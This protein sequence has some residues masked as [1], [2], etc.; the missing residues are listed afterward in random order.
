MEH[1]YLRSKIIESI[2]SL[3]SQIVH[4]RS[5]T[6]ALVFTLMAGDSLLEIYF[7]GNQAIRMDSKAAFDNTFLEYR[8]LEKVSNPFNIHIDENS[9]LFVSPALWDTFFSY[10]SFHGRLGFLV[11]DSFQKNK[12]MN[13]KNGDE[14]INPLMQRMF[15]DEAE[16]VFSEALSRID[17]VH[18][19]REKLE[20][21]FLMEA[22]ELMLE[23]SGL[24]GAAAEPRVA[25]D[26]AG[27][28]IEDPA[29]GPPA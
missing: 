21:K 13:W 5:E 28:R 24:R 25:R 11:Y 19:I 1:S 6:T 8:E 20:A 16:E 12:Y 15:G 7:T 23:P 26:A 29:G 22:A 10:Q 2:S 18:Y 17:S 4:I 27:F 9:R 14:I 3:W